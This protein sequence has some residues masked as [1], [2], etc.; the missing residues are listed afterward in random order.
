MTME[1]RM[2]E[3]TLTAL[4]GSIAKW[5]A[6]VD[7]TGIDRGTENCP[8]CEMFYARRCGGCP[9]MERTGR[10]FCADSPYKQWSASYGFG[11]GIGRSKHLKA[12]AEAELAFLRELLPTRPDSASTS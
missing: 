12:A 8:L 7:G 6:I 3:S 1:A 11:Q 5:Q 4:E 9:V 10:P 2:D